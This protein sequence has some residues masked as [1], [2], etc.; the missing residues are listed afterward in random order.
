M[1]KRKSDR[2]IERTKKRLSGALISLMA[3]RR[4]DEITVQDILDRAEAGRA[5]FYQHFR[6][7]EDLL[8]TGIEQLRG[9]L[10]DEWKSASARGGPGAGRLGFSLPLFRHFDS[11][12]HLYRALVGGE[13]F[14]VVERMMRRML[15]T[16]LR[17]ELQPRRA[18]GRH[19]AST[20]I[21]LEYVTGAMWAVVS[22][23]MQCRQ[24]PSPETMDALFREL[25]LP[26]LDAALRMHSATYA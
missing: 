11:H 25:T 5:T 26:A 10:L 4:Y 12:R 21:A 9:H 14:V 18:T 23:W 2:R 1:E 7:K 3:E 13:G 20:D 22:W 17:Q 8:G 16:L 19:E 15:A 6:S 24:P